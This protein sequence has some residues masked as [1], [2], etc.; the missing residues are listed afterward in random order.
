MYNCTCKVEVIKYSFNLDDG[1]TL[2]GHNEGFI[3][4]FDI[5]PPFHT[6]L[7]IRNFTPL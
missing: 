5:W 4:P 7:T 6:F 3:G 2:I 1:D